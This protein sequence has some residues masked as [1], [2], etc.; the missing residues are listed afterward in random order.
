MD[1]VSPFERQLGV[2]F[3]RTVRKRRLQLHLT[4]QDVALAARMDRSHY[5][6]MEA[7]RSDRKTNRPAN[8]TLNTLVRLAIVFQCTIDDL[9]APIVRLMNDYPEEVHEWFDSLEFKS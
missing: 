9:L 1:Y 2:L 8:P 5:Q 4:Q 3:G 7:G 6:A